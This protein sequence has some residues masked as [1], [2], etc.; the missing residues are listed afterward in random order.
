[1]LTR[2]RTRER[3]MMMVWPKA[4]PHCHGDLIRDLDLDGP[5]VG[6]I[7]CGRALNESQERTLLGLS[8]TRSSG[9][10]SPSWSGAGSRAA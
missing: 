9:R 7:Q 3:R 1:M 8:I 5:Y 2:S 4:C 10:T 6:C